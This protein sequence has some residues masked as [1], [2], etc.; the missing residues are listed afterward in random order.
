M[1][2][3]DFTD[4]PVDTGVSKKIL[5]HL[6]KKRVIREDCDLL[7]YLK[8]KIKGKRVL[9]IGICEHDLSHLNSDEWRHKTIRDNCQYSIGIDILENLVELL[10]NKGYNV[11]CVDATSDVFLGEHFDVV[12]IG[13]VIEHVNDAVKLL[14]F[15][16]R[17]LTKDGII[18]ASTPNPFYLNNIFQAIK[19]GT[20]VANFE[21][22]SWITPSMALELARRSE[23]ELQN[24]ILVRKSKNFIKHILK[25]ML[26]AELANGFFIYQFGI[27]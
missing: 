13:D 10:K 19:E 26:P 15:S 16:R 23:L 8:E 1:N 4:N 12:F 27:K 9:D 3:T 18:I 6:L 14:T 5:D 11:R 21:H 20:F 17:H 2:W 22:V 24:Y 7:D 25:K